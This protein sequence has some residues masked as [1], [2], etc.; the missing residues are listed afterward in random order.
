MGSKASTATIDKIIYFAPKYRRQTEHTKSLEVIGMD[1]EAYTSG[2]CF[3]VC[4][5]D[6]SI[7]T[8]ADFPACLFTRAYRGKNFVVYNLKYD[9]GAF[10]QSF[11]AKQ[12]KELQTQ[13]QCTVG[14][15][16]YKTIANKCF[17]IRKG[18]NTAHIYDIASFF[19]G[20]LDAVAKDFLG[21]GKIDS[22]PK[23]YTKPYVK[24]HWDSIGKYCIG[25]AVLVK[26]LADALI[27]MF[28]SFEVYPQKLYS[29][30]YISYQYFS[31]TCPYINV[32]RYWDEYRGVL[33]FAMRS[34]NG[35]KFEV[36]QKGPGYYYEYD[37]VLAYSYEMSNLID[38]R[39]AR[40]V[41]SKTYRKGAI[42]GF[43][44][45]SIKI[46]FGIFSPVAI[47]KGGVNFYPIGEYRK[48]ITK[49]EYEYLI[50]IGCDITIHKG[51]WL[52]KTYLTYP[53]R[54]EIKRLARIKAALKHTDKKMEYHVVKKFLNSFYGKTVQLIYKNGKY[55]AGASWN[56]IYGSMI[57]SNCRIRMSRLQQSHP[58]VIA[59][60]TD[61]IISTAPLEIPKTQAI[62]A[63]SYECEGE[64]LILGSGIYQVGLKS[65]FRG[66]PTKTPLVDLIPSS[67]RLL[68]ISKERP[69]T[70][71]EV[72][73]RGLSLDRINRFEEIP[74]KLR[75][76]FD[77][78]R[79]WL[80]DYEDY[81]EVFKRQVESV[82]WMLDSTDS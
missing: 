49:S 63:L 42:Y 25:D 76:N 66:F 58:S 4:M 67:G 57:T 48:V 36:T 12:L 10:V 17:S 29:I 55:K 80:H 41:D 52:H 34:Y 60:H 1:T 69:Y 24:K 40:V 61:S 50:S 45:C 82:P 75:L 31:N 54:Q 43:L 53:Y 39:D 64:G 2:V 72:A 18:K 5:S 70:W 81:S 32:R 23:K 78:K 20:K 3:M 7:F 11:T 38:V 51:Y 28:E 56:P 44:D 33:E 71:R 79:I 6:G 68:N 46:P 59:V 35:G 27:S 65:R 13:E 62:G 26:E 8:P 30:A 73:H 21:K 14:A 47:K 77:N 19:E 74:R 16:T 9:S 22:D 15:Y 37:L